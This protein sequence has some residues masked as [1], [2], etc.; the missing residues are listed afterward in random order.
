MAAANPA[1]SFLDEATCSICLDSFQDPVMIINCGHNF[2]RKCISKFRKRS[3]S[4]AYCPECRQLFSWTNLKP[5][6]Q[7]GN[8]V[9]KAKHLSLQLNCSER[10]RLCKEHQMPLTLFCNSDE[11]LLCKGCDRSKAHRGHAVVC[12]EEAAAKYKVMPLL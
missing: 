2:C 3:D 6:R 10:G 7:L 12:T 5:N 11:T 1:E 4:S 8:I 9:E